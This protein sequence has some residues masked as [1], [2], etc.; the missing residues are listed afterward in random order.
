MVDDNGAHVGGFGV[1]MLSFDGSFG[2]WRDDGSAVA[3]THLLHNLNCLATSF[4]RGIVTVAG[5]VSIFSPISSYSRR[6][7]S[8][9]IV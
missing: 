6:S 8:S 4:Q 2:L 1:D 9:Q 7:T 3:A 5:G